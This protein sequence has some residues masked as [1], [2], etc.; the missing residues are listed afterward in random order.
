MVRIHR[1]DAK[2]LAGATASHVSEQ[3]H[4]IR[5]DADIVNDGSLEALAKAALRCVAD[6]GQLTQQAIS[7]AGGAA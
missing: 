2:P 7:V 6:P 1:P 3:H 5:A 4:R